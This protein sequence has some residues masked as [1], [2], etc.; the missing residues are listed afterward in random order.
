MSFWYWHQHL[1]KRAGS[2]GITNFDPLTA[3]FRIGLIEVYTSC[4]VGI[5]LFPNMVQ[6]ARLL[7]VTPTQQCTSEGRR[8]RTILRFYPRNESTGFEYLW[9]DTNLRK[10]LENDQLVFT[11]NRKS[12]GVAKCAVWKH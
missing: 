5:A 4:S 10:A 12:P 1:T 2:N 11:I 9:L 7:F 6:T 3:P 8:T